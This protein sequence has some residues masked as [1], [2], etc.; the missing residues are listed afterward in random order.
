[1]SNLIAILRDPGAPFEPR[2]RGFSLSGNGARG[3]ARLLLGKRDGSSY[4]VLWQPVS[5]WDAEERRRLRPPPA[6]VRLRL[7]ERAARAAL[8]RPLS[9]RAPVW[10]RSSVESLEVEVSADPVIVRLQQG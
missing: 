2:G 9:G 6:S 10:A 7:D 3:V 1:V 8:Y 5:V 4:L